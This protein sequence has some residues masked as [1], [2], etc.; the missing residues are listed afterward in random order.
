MSYRNNT[1]GKLEVPKIL[2]SLNGFV[3]SL[4]G[5]RYSRGFRLSRSLI[6]RICRGRCAGR[7][8]WQAGLVSG[9]SCLGP[10]E[11]YSKDWLVRATALNITLLFF[12]YRSYCILYFLHLAISH[13]LQV[14]KDDSCHRWYEV[15]IA[16]DFAILGRAAGWEWPSHRANSAGRGTLGAPSG[17]VGG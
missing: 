3:G 11:S 12:L 17:G 1:P 13:Y 10:I 9:I 7:R 16:W 15:D 6:W 8:R 4:N 2:P 14:V 5:R